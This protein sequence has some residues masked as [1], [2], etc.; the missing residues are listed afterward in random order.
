M[1]RRGNQ[2]NDISLLVEA[3]SESIKTIEVNLESQQKSMDE[4]RSNMSTGTVQMSH[5]ERSNGFSGT[6]ETNSGSN[7]LR[8][9]VN[10]V[11][12]N[13]QISGIDRTSVVIGDSVS[14]DA[15]ILRRALK[16]EHPVCSF[17]SGDCVEFLKEFNY[18]S[19]LNEWNDDDKVKNFPKALK[20]LA[21]NWFVSSVGFEHSFSW[22]QLE[23]MFLKY[24]DHS[25]PEVVALR[26]IRSFKIKEGENMRQ[27]SARLL[28]VI[29]KLTSDKKLQAVYL[30]QSLPLRYKEKVKFNR[31]MTFDDLVRE[32]LLLEERFGMIDVSYN[33]FTNRTSNFR[34]TDREFRNPLNRTSG[35][36]NN[37]YSNEFNRNSLNNTAT[38]NRPFQR[39]SSFNNNWQR[40]NNN[41]RNNYPNNNYSNN[42]FRDNNS[43]SNNNNWQRNNNYFR[44][45][46]SN[47]NNNN[48][49]QSNDRRVRFQA[50]NSTLNNRQPFINNNHIINNSNRNSQPGRPPG[51]A[52][53]ASNNLQRNRSPSPAPQGVQQQRLN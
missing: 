8:P 31:N 34:R 12:N 45:N 9:D 44:N 51:N 30:L 40:N 38:N 41:F 50:D 3:M 33:N 1:P 2:S 22:N 39:N 13:G 18:I 27:F 17:E 49:F 20:G 52:V 53:S 16:P 25:M 28:T 37:F 19:M 7:S 21:R 35:G 15:N 23:Q 24:F 5:N 14:V 29:E 6:C 48:A 36:N 42:Y 43:N 46:N 11:E 47:S 32:C 4:L 26:E 10:L